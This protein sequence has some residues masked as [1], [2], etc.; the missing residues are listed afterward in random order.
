[1]AEVHS[2]SYGILNHAC[3]ICGGR[4][5]VSVNEVR[6]A[7]C[8]ITAPYAD[9]NKAPHRLLCYCGEKIG[10][11]CKKNPSQKP[12]SP[13]QVIV[14]YVESTPRKPRS[15]PIIVELVPDVDDDS[16]FQ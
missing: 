6:C 14:E 7:E 1:M 10:L 15:K 4:L 16:L 3:R 8:G 9:G 13:Q 11:R 5:L 12:E 2:F